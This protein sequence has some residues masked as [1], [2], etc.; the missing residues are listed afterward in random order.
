MSESLLTFS[1]SDLKLQAGGGCARLR[2]CHILDCHASSD[3]D[4]HLVKDEVA[5][6]D[7]KG[8]AGG[9]RK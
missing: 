8:K 1:G 9:D 5:H 2:P 4:L 6:N 3:F 7:R